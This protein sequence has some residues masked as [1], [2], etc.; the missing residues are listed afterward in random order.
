MHM[1]EI[2]LC[3][4]VCNVGDHKCFWIHSFNGCFFFANA[5]EKEKK[6]EKMFELRMSLTDIVHTILPRKV[7]GVRICLRSNDASQHNG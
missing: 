3:D 6:I 7:C 4:L 5:F 1:I 2:T